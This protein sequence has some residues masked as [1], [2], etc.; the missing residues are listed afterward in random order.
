MMVSVLVYL[1]PS[2]IIKLDFGQI[3][4]EIYDVKEA[5]TIKDPHADKH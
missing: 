1:C 2:A 5:Q 3:L 4:V